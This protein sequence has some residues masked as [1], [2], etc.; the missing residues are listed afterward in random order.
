MVLRNG[1]SKE[2]KLYHLY[3]NRSC[4]YGNCKKHIWPAIEKES[5]VLFFMIAYGKC[6]LVLDAKILLCYTYSIKYC[7]VRL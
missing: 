7:V 2:L 6:G 4:L 1:Q 5:K 3:T